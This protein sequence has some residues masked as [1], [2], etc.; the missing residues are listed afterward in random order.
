MVA[1]LWAR[2]I[3][4]SGRCMM[5]RQ[6]AAR[7]AQPT[8]PAAPARAWADRRRASGWPAAAAASIF[9]VSCTTSVRNSSSTRRK[10]AGGRSRARSAAKTGALGMRS[11]WMRARCRRAL[12]LRGLAGW[13]GQLRPLPCFAFNFGQKRGI[14]TIIR[15]GADGGAATA[16]ARR[17]G[18]DRRERVRPA[19]GRCGRSGGHRETGSR[20]RCGC[21]GADGRAP[22]R[23]AATGVGSHR[24]RRGSRD[25][26]AT[27]A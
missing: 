3:S 2:S 24:R 18:R 10:S 15:H 17:A 5:M 21:R 12:R 27:P 14:V 8:V 1:A 4:A 7:S 9:S 25:R 26:R 22:H 13:R 11:P 23:S 20:S 6:A 19:S 16:A